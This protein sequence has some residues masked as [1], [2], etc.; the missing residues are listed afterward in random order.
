MKK[1]FRAQ[2]TLHFIFYFH[3]FFIIFIKTYDMFLNFTFKMLI[4]KKK[5]QKNKYIYL[6]IKKTHKTHLIRL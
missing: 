2:L 6:S 4:K 3:F 5:I 1:C